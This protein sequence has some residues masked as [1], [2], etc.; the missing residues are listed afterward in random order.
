MTALLLYIVQTFMDSAVVRPEPLEVLP[1]IVRLVSAVAV[2]SILFTERR[3]WQV[4]APAFLLA[5]QIY[6][7][8]QVVP[9]QTAS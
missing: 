5:I 2:L 7:A 8:I 6:W 1:Q 3:I 4:L 9:V